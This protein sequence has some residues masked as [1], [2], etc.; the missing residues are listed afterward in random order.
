MLLTPTLALLT[1]VF[2]FCA[3]LHVT[4]SRNGL[5]TRWNALDHVIYAL[6]ETT[7]TAY[8]NYLDIV[9]PPPS[10][11]S[12]VYSPALHR[13]EW[14]YRSSAV[15]ILDLVDGSSKVQTVS[16]VDSPSLLPPSPLSPTKTADAGVPAGH[17]LPTLTSPIHPATFEQFPTYDP[18]VPSAI[19]LSVA[20]SL[21]L[22]GSASLLVYTLIFAWLRVSRPRSSRLSILLI[23]P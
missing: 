8:E 18:S 17:L 13:A 9:A 10:T 7:V 4:N 20:Q 3:L 16:S 12:P 1:I 19:T 21:G 15:R 2:N 22:I 23:A 5:S 14:V 6:E 11:S